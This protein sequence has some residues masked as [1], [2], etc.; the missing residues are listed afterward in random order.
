LNDPFSIQ[1]VTIRM[2]RSRLN[3]Q[4]IDFIRFQ[5]N[6]PCGKRQKCESIAN[7]DQEKNQKNH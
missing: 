4:I 1:H 7:T 2:S 3:G 6:C 5:Q